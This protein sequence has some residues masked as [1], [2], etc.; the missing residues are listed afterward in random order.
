MQETSTF[1]NYIRKMR[2]QVRNTGLTT[3]WRPL[4]L[5][6]WRRSKCV[7]KTQWDINRHINAISCQGTID[8]RF[9]QI[10]VKTKVP[11]QDKYVCKIFHSAIDHAKCHHGFGFLGD[12]SN[13]GIYSQKRN[14]EIKYDRIFRQ[15]RCWRHGITYPN[16]KLQI[17]LHR[18]KQPS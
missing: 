8:C 4:S 3:K 5:L 1:C 14:S 13:F 9:K 12:S 7:G 16:V 2:G 15:F 11:L 10:V 18:A 6:C 17:D